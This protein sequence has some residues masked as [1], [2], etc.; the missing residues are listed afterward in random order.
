MASTSDETAVMR[1]RAV[2]YALA[3]ARQWREEGHHVVL[4][5]DSI[6]RYAMAQREIGLAAGEPPTARGYT[7]N[8]FAALPKLIEQCGAIRSGGAISGVFTVL[9]ETDDNDDPICEV[10]KSL[11]DGHIVLSRGMADRGHFPAIDV[12]RSVSRLAATV[13]DP[14]Q[15]KRMEHAREL[16]ATHAEAKLLIDSG[17]Y[18]AGSSAKTDEAI[19]RHEALEG[20]LRQTLHECVELTATHSALATCLDEE[21]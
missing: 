4:F 10:M 17:F 2:H 6:S 15:Q 11:L 19:A 5:L 18:T 20:F 16:M 9:S 8:V 1:V 12:T 21:L 13:S 14:K 7:P 3:L